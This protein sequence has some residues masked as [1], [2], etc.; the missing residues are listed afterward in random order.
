MK[1]EKHTKEKVMRASSTSQ[2]FSPKL[3]SLQIFSQL[4]TGFSD[5]LSSDLTSDTEAF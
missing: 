4:D 2:C 5:P 1:E 3:E